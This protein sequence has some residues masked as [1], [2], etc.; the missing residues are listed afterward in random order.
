MHVFHNI[1]KLSPTPNTS[2]Q[3]LRNS[4]SWTY[5]EP[6]GSCCRHLEIEKSRARSLP[7]GARKPSAGGE[8]RSTSA[9][10]RLS[11]KKVA[12]KVSTGSCQYSTLQRFFNKL[13]FWKT[14]HAP[15][16]EEHLCDTCRKEEDEPKKVLVL[17]QTPRS[18]GETSSAVATGKSYQTCSTCGGRHM[19]PTHNRNFENLQR[20]LNLAKLE[21]NKY[22][23][24]V[25]DRP[26]AQTTIDLLNP[27]SLEQPNASKHGQKPREPRK[28][29]DKPRVDP[30]IQKLYKS[31]ET[32]NEEE[33]DSFVILSKRQLEDEV[34]PQ[35]STVAPLDREEKRMILKLTPKL[36]SVTLDDL[37]TPSPQPPAPKTRVAHLSKFP[38]Q[39]DSSC[40]HHAD[41][42][43]LGKNNRRK[44]HT[45]RAL[46]WCSDLSDDRNAEGAK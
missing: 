41:M 14:T 46:C 13:K 2:L 12:F 6:I 9:I 28:L 15:D 1:L 32:I 19:I 16:A 4:H 43:W 20:K 17:K 8:E 31:T 33:V 42:Q 35:P 11:N 45:R 7:R 5:L 26:R 10:I 34:D 21:A 27:N 18:V 25:P 30:L 37:V 38:F 39:C 36:D 24:L 22:G 23:K 3:I 44:L 40:S 29:T